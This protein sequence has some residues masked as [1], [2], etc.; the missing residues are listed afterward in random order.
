MVVQ[1]ARRRARGPLRRILLRTCF[2]AVAT[3][4]S[5]RRFCPLAAP[6][7]VVSGHR[8]ATRV[9]ARAA[10]RPSSHDAAR[11]GASDAR[12][13]QLPHGAAAMVAAIEP[14]RIRQTL[15]S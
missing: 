9:L 3:P 4:A 10:S 15:L 7:A 5:V 8:C 2:V 13:R 6:L 12:Q 1:R 14:G 11:N